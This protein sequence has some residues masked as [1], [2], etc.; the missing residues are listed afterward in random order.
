MEL[1]NQL[2]EKPSDESFVC[3]ACLGRNVELRSIFKAGRICGQ[4]TSLA[5]MLALCT[6]L[7]VSFVLALC[8]ITN[9]VVNNGSTCSH[10]SIHVNCAQSGL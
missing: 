5:D 9:S 4:I 3:R 7:E 6:N 2:D 10:N 1:D 8:A